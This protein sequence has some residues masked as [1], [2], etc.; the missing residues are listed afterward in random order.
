MNRTLINVVTDALAALAMLGMIATGTVLRFALPPGTNRS[1]SLWGL[2]RHQWGDLHFWLALAAL[3]V[4]VIHLVLH[5]TWVVSVVRRWLIGG[6][7]GTPS[8]Q[9]RVWAALATIVVLS[10]SLAGFWKWSLAS[11]RPVEASPQ[12]G[13]A[14]GTESERLRGSV[15]LAEAAS[16][17]G[18]SAQEVRA[19]LSLPG[20]T[21][22]TDRLGQIA[23]NLRIDMQELRRRLEARPEGVAP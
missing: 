4:V 20:E 5:W 6:G 22:E 11:V 1:L 9:A 16:M 12:T 2:T 14:V 3:G 17:L 15:T 23:R 18:C 19:R 10:L 8:G 13:E 7:Q 21:P